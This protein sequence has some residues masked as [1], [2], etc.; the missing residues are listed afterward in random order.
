[1]RGRVGARV[2]VKVG[3]GAGQVR[4]RVRGWSGHILPKTGARWTGS[5][6]STT[7]HS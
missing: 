6:G 5:A 7:R 2:R 3:V 1:M 4:V